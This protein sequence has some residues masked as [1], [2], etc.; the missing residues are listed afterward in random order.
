MIPNI[1]QVLYLPERVFFED[2][3]GIKEKFDGDLDKHV[4]LNDPETRRIIGKLGVKTLSSAI[5]TAIYGIRGSEDD[6]LL[7][8]RIGERFNSIKRIVDSKKQLSEEGWKI[9]LLKELEVCKVQNLEIIYSLGIFNL[10]SKPQEERVF[11]NS[12][13]RRLYVRYKQEVPFRLIAKEIAMVL[14]PIL[15]LSDLAPAI[16]EVLQSETSED[17]ENILDEYGFDKI[18]STNVEVSQPGISISL[19]GNSEGERANDST[20]DNEYEKDKSIEKVK[21]DFQHPSE[22]IIE[23]SNAS[24]TDTNTEDR[25]EEEASVKFT[26]DKKSSD[27]NKDKVGSSKAF[28]S[29]GHTA[30]IHKTKDSGGTHKKKQSHRGKLRS[31]VLSPIQAEERE[32]E[33]LAMC[34][35]IERDEIDRAGIQRVIKHEKENAREPNEKDHYHKGYDIESLNSKGEIDRY[36]EV[37][38]TK[39]KW[40]GFEVELTHAQFEKARELGAKY[41]L[42]VVDEALSNNPQV[43]EI[44]NPALRASGYL[45]DRPWADGELINSENSDE[46]E[47]ER[48][49]ITSD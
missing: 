15:D 27:E 33:E 31:Y 23:P 48:V 29:M 38:S 7:T 18:E 32:R 8:K 3:S 11:Y 46:I 26:T 42:Y 40:D 2:K 24:I 14:N 9:D 13:E 5:N 16:N 36:I 19:L 49:F 6:P 20:Q 45:Y 17:A 12:E 43:Y 28:G 1:D 39:S 47:S 4:I 21:S 30:D 44:N 37:K 25:S 34:S 10:K 35:R 41:F 22:G